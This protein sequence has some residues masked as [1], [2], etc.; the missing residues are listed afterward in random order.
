MRGLRRNPRTNFQFV[1]HGHCPTILSK[2]RTV[3]ISSIVSPSLEAPQEQQRRT[4]AW[5]CECA[6]VAFVRAEPAHAPPPG[7]LTPLVTGTSIAD[8]YV[9]AHSLAATKE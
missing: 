5:A 2:I 1:L 8:T 6:F 3:R 7:S 4:A 9:A